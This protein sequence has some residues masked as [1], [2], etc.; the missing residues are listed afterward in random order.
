MVILLLEEIRY[1]LLNQIA[2][3][4]FI[5]DAQYSKKGSLNIEI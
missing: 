5:F 2:L 1:V 3:N 4:Y